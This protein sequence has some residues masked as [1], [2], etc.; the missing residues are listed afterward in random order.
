MQLVNKKIAKRLRELDYK[1]S[2]SHF[3]PKEP[4]S[5]IKPLPTEDGDLPAPYYEEVIEWLRDTKK[6]SIEPYYFKEGRWSVTIC[7]MSLN[8]PSKDYILEDGY[9]SFTEAAEAALTYT[10][11]TM[12]W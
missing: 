6:I 10:L 9:N 7:K 1:G 3:Y 12:I 8:D 4:N 5:P 2:C 11:N